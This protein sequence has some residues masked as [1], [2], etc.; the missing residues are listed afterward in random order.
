MN[1]NFIG[2]FKNIAPL[3]IESKKSLG[4]YADQNIM[5]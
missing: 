1:N 3:Y 2:P 5:N 4:F